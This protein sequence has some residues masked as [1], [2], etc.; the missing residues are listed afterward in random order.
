MNLRRLTLVSLLLNAA[1]AAALQWPGRT[2]VVVSIPPSGADAPVALAP[3]EIQTFELAS[4]ILTNRVPFRWS[5]V[6]SSDFATYVANLR[7]VNCPEGVI[8]DL[9]FWELERVYEARRQAL[10]VEDNFWKPAHVRA[11]AWKQ[12]QQAVERLNL[13]QR[14]V[15][16]HL[17]GLWWTRKAWD[18]WYDDSFATIAEVLVGFVGDKRTL[19]A[20]AVYFSGEDGTRQARD[21][22][23][24]LPPAQAEAHARAV[25]AAWMQQFAALM[26]P[27]QFEEFR[28]RV[29]TV[30][31]VEAKHD[32]QFRLSGAEM[33][34]VARIR[35][36]FIPAFSEKLILSSA[37]H[38]DE[39]RDAALEQKIAAALGPERYEGY[40][41]AKDEHFGSLQS[42]IKETGGSRETTLKAWQ[43]CQAAEA[44]TKRLEASG[45]KTDEDLLTARKEVAEVTRQTL[46]TLLGEKA[47]RDLY[48][49]TGSWLPK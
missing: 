27:E 4:T 30:D 10:P 49:Q 17:V 11:A 45:P 2:P 23:E 46:T 33:R 43:V 1:L 8:Q 9:V 25:H 24:L 18:F 42:L 6:E 35:D 39:E 37:F 7:D 29:A 15:M 26:T 44:E 34:Q 38:D 32:D 40:Q 13:E 36:E 5:Q 19:N 14:A 3:G 31:G 47:S 16:K 22:A 20:V 28:L 12:H 41:R 21:K 48:Q